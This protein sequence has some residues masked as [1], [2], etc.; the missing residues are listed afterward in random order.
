MVSNFDIK[1]LLENAV[2]IWSMLP[3]KIQ[4]AIVLV[5]VLWGIAAII[6]ALSN[7]G[8]AGEHMDVQ[9]A[10]DSVF[11]RIIKRFFKI[12]IPKK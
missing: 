10:R 8:R 6:V 7:R 12:I 1:V 11:K 5:I 2:A 3:I 4:A 9:G